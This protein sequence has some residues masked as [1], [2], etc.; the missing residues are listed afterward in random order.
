MLDVTRLEYADTMKLKD[1]DLAEILSRACQDFFPLFIKSQRELRVSGTDQ[2][3][4]CKGNKDLIYR[5]I[6]NLLDNALEYGPA[7][8]PVEATLKNYTI[9]ITDYGKKIPEVKRRAIFKR[10]HKDRSPS[11]RKSGAGLGLAIVAKT[12]EIHGG[13]ADLEKTSEN[14]NTFRMIFT[15]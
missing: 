13:H 3:V 7:K 6:C 8:T 12:M 2:P 11:A 4:Y 15:R 14:R 9:A 10:F 1:V 5:A